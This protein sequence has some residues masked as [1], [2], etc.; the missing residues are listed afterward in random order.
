MAL[1]YSNLAFRTLDMVYPILSYKFS[2]P[3]EIDGAVVRTRLLDVVF[4]SALVRTVFVQAPAGYGKTTL[5]QQIM[6]RQQS[7]D[8]ALGWLTLEE[9]DND[10][11]RFLA[12]LH[13][14]IDRAFGKPLMALN[15]ETVASGPAETFSTVEEI[16]ARLSELERPLSLFIDEFQVV[17][18]EVIIALMSRLLERLPT[19]ATFYIGS[20]SLPELGLGRLQLRNSALILKAE[21]LRFNR[22]ETVSFFASDND[23]PLGEELV[24]DIFNR[25]EGWPAAL[26]LA[27]LAIRGGA[28]KPIVDMLEF[29]SEPQFEEYLANN[30]L[31]LQPQAI[32]D[33]LLRSSILERL[34]PD[35]CRHLT[36]EEDAENV[37]RQL[38]ISGLF[39]RPLG[40]DRSWFRFHSLFS[41]YLRNQLRR[42]QP[43]ETQ[44]L[45]ELAMEWFSANDYAD[46]AIHHA[47][48]S[49]NYAVA[50]D[51]LESWSAQLIREGRLTTI[52]RWLDVLPVEY[53]L[54]QPLLQMKVLWALLFLRRFHKARPLLDALVQDIERGDAKFAGS[55]TI[56]LL[57]SVRHLMEDD[58]VAAGK[59][60][61]DIDLNR[62]PRDSFEAFEFG[63]IANIQSLFERTKGN[64]EIAQNK[65]RVGSLYSERGEAAFSGA[66][67]MA[68][69][70][71]GYFAQADLASALTQYRKGLEAATHRRGSHAS[72][73]VTACF[74]EA[75]YYD[76]A[77]QEAKSLLEDALPLISQACMPDALAVA[78]VTL[79]KIRNLDGDEVDAD[80]VLREAEKIGLD[81][82]LPRV[83]NAVMWERVRQLLQRDEIEEARQLADRIAESH[84]VAP[85]A[86]HIF[87]A[88][89]LDGD[90]IGFARLLIYEENYGP[91]LKLLCTLIADAQHAGRTLRVLKLKTLQAGALANKGNMAAAEIIAGEVVRSLATKGFT[92][93]LLEEPPFVRLLEQLYSA[94]GATFDALP[95][96]VAN[97]VEK[98]ATSTNRY[99]SNEADEIQAICNSLT[100]R[101]IEILAMLAH[102]MSNKIIGAHIFVSENTVKYHLRSIFSKLGVRNRTEATNVA[103]RYRII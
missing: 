67:A 54:N 91:A 64:F 29:S 53:V 95:L 65:A 27:R 12:H 59:A 7:S 14:V 41:S 98:I 4:A 94:K 62:E 18:N 80:Y 25:T 16:L 99:I 13:A 35:L 56:P 42:R 85:D 5:L 49:E 86:P 63:A 38:E 20:R 45:H 101:E 39:I 69:S 82:L 26:Q 77:L 66:Y 74:A 93:L 87:H 32:Q 22:D 11:A 97:Y 79:A 52:E 75:L 30:V 51:I 47:V 1:V 43:G 55:L 72:A 68:F 46:D 81:S 19:E 3:Q 57:L 70:G 89:E 90:E 8:A 21:E 15:D 34:S 83:V 88:E 24:D 102:G 40:P 31:A 73:V 76:D 58:I 2:A 60:V 36:G 50:A 92:R 28:D 44:K 100:D 103:V 78:H 10:P 37:L 71:L 17:S 48:A 23:V 96:E 61:I 9:G 33:F 84:A 6:S